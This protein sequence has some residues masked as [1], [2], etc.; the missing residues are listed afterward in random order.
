M[1]RGWCGQPLQVATAQDPLQP[2]ASTFPRI[3]EFRG[4]RLRLNRMSQGPS[5]E[6]Q[7]Q[8]ECHSPTRWRKAANEPKRPGHGPSAQA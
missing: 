2:R 6:M 3:A 8:H 1:F 5:Q 4:K 7:V